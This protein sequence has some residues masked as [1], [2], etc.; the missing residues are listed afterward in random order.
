MLR[1]FEKTNDLFADDGLQGGEGASGRVVLPGPHIS[2]K[3][4]SILSSF[5]RCPNH[6]GSKALLLS[7]FLNEEKIELGVEMEQGEG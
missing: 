2:N 6:S 1:R 4:K 7:S 5:Q 3:A